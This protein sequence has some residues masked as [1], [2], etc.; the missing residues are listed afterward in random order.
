MTR[1]FRLL[2]RLRILTQVAFVGLFLYL[3]LDTRFVADRPAG[4]VERFFHFDPLLGLSTLLASRAAVAAF[5][6]AFITV[7]VTVVLGRHVCGWVCPLGAVLQFFS[8]VF[9]KGRWHRPRI[10][11]SRH[12]GWKY[13]ILV[14]ILVGS[15]FTISLAGFLDPLSLLYRSFAAAVLPALAV[16][17]RATATLLHQFGASSAGDGLAGLVQNLTVNA[18]FHQGLAIGLIFAGV[19]MLNLVRERFW[20]RYLCPAGA[21]LGVLGRWSLLKL[22]VD[23]RTCDHCNLCVLHCETQASPCPSGDWRPA[24]CVYCYT[25]ASV[26]PRSAISFPMALAPAASR[27]VD[28]LRRRLVLAPVLGVAAVPLFRISDSARRPS[29]KLIRPPGS[30]PEPE[31]LALCVKCGECLKACPTNGL[32]PAL[33]EAGIEGLWTPVLVPHIGYCEYYCALCTEVCPTAAIR[34]LTVDEKIRTRIGTAWIKTHR[35]LPYAS[36]ETCTVCEESCPT[37]PKAIVLHRTEVLMADG[38]LAVPRAP[39][40]DLELCIGCGV[41]ETKCPVVDEPAIYCTSAGETRASRNPPSFDAPADPGERSAQ[42]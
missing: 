17:T 32:Q 24:E 26:C 42:P 23:S 10:E 9:K 8:F 4:Q 36:G 25:C 35:C 39:V 5:S 14:F 20:C 33:G 3:L 30:L 11:G 2:Q 19:V 18:T 34:E 6:L 22:K 40:V 29:E 27:P 1:P 41:C 7:A 21:M 12:L 15:A 28:R 38:S 13:L 37:S 16:S 31:F